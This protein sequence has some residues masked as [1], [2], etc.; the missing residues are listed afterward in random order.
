MSEEEIEFLRGLDELS[1]R[2][3]VIIA[4]CGCCG[5]PSLEPRWYEESFDKGALW[6]RYVYDEK[7]EWQAVY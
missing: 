4:G 7:V 1:R 3:G 5:S 2:T 6:H